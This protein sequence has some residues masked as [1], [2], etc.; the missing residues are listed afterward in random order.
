VVRSGAPGQERQ[1]PA[2]EAEGGRRHLELSRGQL[3]AKYS[4]HLNLLLRWAVLRCAYRSG[5]RLVWHLSM[6]EGM[7]SRPGAGAILVCR[8]V[9]P[10][11]WIG[12][13]AAGL[14]LQRTRTSVRAG[15]TQHVNSLTHFNAAL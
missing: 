10:T 7:R 9:I 15:R 12:A 3:H 14:N 8:G 13:S 5:A 6:L 11:S 2:R 4:E 1:N